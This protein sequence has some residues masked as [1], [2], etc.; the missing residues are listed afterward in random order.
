[1]Y[2]EGSKR[3]RGTMHRCYNRVKSLKIDDPS[4]TNQAY[5]LT[6]KAAIVLREIADPVEGRWVL[7]KERKAYAMHELKKFVTIEVKHNSQ[8]LLGIFTPRALF[9]ETFGKT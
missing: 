8:S 1:M 3:F 9:F 6:M 4:C 5:N 2:Y 7:K